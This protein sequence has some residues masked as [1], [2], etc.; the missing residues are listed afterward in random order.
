MPAH[1]GYDARRHG[2]GRMLVIGKR[3]TD[4][5]EAAP[6]YEMLPRNATMTTSTPKSKSKD[7][8]IE[9][10]A[11]ELDHIAAELAVTKD[12]FGAII[13]TPY[14]DSIADTGSAFLQNHVD[15]VDELSERLRALAPLFKLALIQGGKTKQDKR[16]SL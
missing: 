14:G 2:A 13:Q 7:P 10:I 4:G 3:G 1:I 12:L 9:Q 16:P 6:D 8:E 11:T 5:I 15:R